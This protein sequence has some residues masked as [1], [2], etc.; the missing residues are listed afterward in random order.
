MSAAEYRTTRPR[1][2]RLTRGGAAPHDREM[3]RGA[4]VVALALAGSVAATVAGC[5]TPAILKPEDRGN[6]WH[7]QPQECAVDWPG[8]AYGRPA[9]CCPPGFVF[10]GNALSRDCPVG[11][12]CPF[13]EQMGDPPPASLGPMDDTLVSRGPTTR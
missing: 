5:A 6:P 4:L 1:P 11:T 7:P 8:P 9:M 13:L 3:E 10:G 12:C 2:A